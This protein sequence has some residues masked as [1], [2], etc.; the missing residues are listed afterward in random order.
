[1]SPGSA[2]RPTLRNRL[3]CGTGCS[4]VAV[5]AIDGPSHGD[6]EAVRRYFTFDEVVAA[7]LAVMNHL[8]LTES[9][10]WVGNAWGGH[11]DIRLAAAE[12]P[13]V[14]SPATIATLVRAFTTGTRCGTARSSRSD[15]RIVP[16]GGDQRHG[17]P[18]DRI[19][20]LAAMANP[21]SLEVYEDQGEHVK[22]FGEEVV[23]DR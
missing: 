11:V 1:M 13:R 22:P 2:A 6:S 10:D 14:R 7:A 15:P 20:E 12:R 5:Y 4:F 8:G 19:Y 16:V 21:S 9:V 23:A 18:A 3:S 17:G